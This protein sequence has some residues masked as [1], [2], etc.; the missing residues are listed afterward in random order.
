[1][2]NETQLS[3]QELID[4][5]YRMVSNSGRMV[6]RIDREDW[7]GSMARRMRVNPR[8]FYDHRGFPSSQWCDYYR[9][10]FSRDVLIVNEEILSK[11]PTSG[12]DPVGYVKCQVNPE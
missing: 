6:A 12:H 7:V 9:R 4:R 1:M 11:I 10:M 8:D 3:A 2:T 5:G